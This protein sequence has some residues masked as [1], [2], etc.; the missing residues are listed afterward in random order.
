MN[1]RIK[2]LLIFGGVFVVCAVLYPPILGF[3][4]GF[5]IVIG[6]RLLVKAITGD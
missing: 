1:E 4:I 5:G 2:G 6:M 3:A